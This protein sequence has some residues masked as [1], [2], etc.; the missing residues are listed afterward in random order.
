MASRVSFP[1]VLAAVGAAA[2]VLWWIN[3]SPD[4]GAVEKVREGPD[5]LGSGVP[6]ELSAPV[7]TLTSSMGDPGG[8]P[9]GTVTTGSLWID[10]DDTTVTATSLVDGEP[11]WT[12]RRDDESI[13]GWVA[14]GDAAWVLFGD[15]L[16]ARVDVDAGKVD[17][18]TEFDRL[19]DEDDAPVLTGD[20]SGGVV[21]QGPTSAERPVWWVGADLDPVALHLPAECDAFDD[22]TSDGER[23]YLIALCDAGERRVMAFATDG[24]SE[25]ESGPSTAS[26][27]E[28]DRGQ[29]AV[30]G[31]VGSEL[32]DAE[33]G[34]A[35]SVVPAGAHALSYVA[36]AD[37]LVV[38]WE[39]D[40]PSGRP[41]L[42][43]WSVDQRRF[44]WRLPG[45]GDRGDVSAP[46]VSDGQVYYT[47]T[48]YG[49][50]PRHRLVVVDV[51]S[52]GTTS[53]EITAPEAEGC[54]GSA[55]F[56]PRIRAGIPGAI[57]VS[58]QD[59]DFCA[60]PVLEVYASASS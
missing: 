55:S 49:A 23:I 50:E 51:V 26:A 56:V 44:V 54:E 41:S 36:V 22:V 30:H 43:V 8:S 31:P 48:A 53:T 32:V 39:G 6:S 13:D 45:M 25:W 3:S 38:A 37:G 40:A 12:Y 19:Y 20:G 15:H 2:V 5:A 42:A 9:S 59:D 4:P 34:E 29:I 16:L 21:L 52:G 11:V 7:V 10:A 17:D 1:V 24:S 28:V 27:L 35:V 58:W 14:S 33:T 18:S 47:E 60:D 46:L 57:V